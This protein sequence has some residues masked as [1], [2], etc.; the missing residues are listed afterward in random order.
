MQLKTGQTRSGTIGHPNWAGHA[1]CTSL[2]SGKYPKNWEIF[3]NFP[4]QNRRAKEKRLKVNT[5]EVRR[6]SK[7]PFL[8]LI[9]E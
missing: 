1:R 8:M 7:M 2:V 4:F 5:K 9:I 3:A 6:F